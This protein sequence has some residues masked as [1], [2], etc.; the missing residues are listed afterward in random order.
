MLDRLAGNTALK[1]DLAA[2]LA[3]DRLA[4]SILL[5][6]EQGC[7]AGFAARCLAADYLY[8]GGGP[9]AEAVLRGQDTECISIRGEGAS[10][11]IKVERIRDAREEITHSALAEDARGRV[12]FVYGAQNMNQSSANA[13]LKIIEEPP[14]GVLF[15]FTAA[16]AAAVLPTIRSRC[17]AY[18]IA[19]VPGEEC[20]AVLRQHLPALTRDAADD[21][22]FLYEGHIGL[23]LAAVQQPDIREALDRARTFAGYARQQDSYRALALTARMEKDRAAA[24]AFF[25]QLAFVGSAALRRPGYGG[26]EAD[27]AAVLL[28]AA[29]KAREALRANGNLRLLLAVFTAESC[30]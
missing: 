2:A 9:H 24:G 20:A 16:S 4:H 21:L 25:Q 7:G 5:V 19:P 18:T 27:R 8:P 29:G 22:A 13:L 6:G 12:L 14:E 30:R 10:G 23:G 11:Q 26:L 17:A 15:L 28:R 3:A 1:Q